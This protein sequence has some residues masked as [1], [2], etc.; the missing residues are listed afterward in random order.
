MGKAEG[1][2]E[3]WASDIEGLKLRGTAASELGKSGVSNEAGANESKLRSSLA[4]GET[5]VTCSFF[6]SIIHDFRVRSV[7]QV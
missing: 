3:L 1:R 4:Q 5:L 2:M 6:S 7:P